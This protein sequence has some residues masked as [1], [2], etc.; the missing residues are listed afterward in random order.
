MIDPSGNAK[1]W[2]AYGQH[3]LARSYMPPVP[4]QLRWGFWDG[5]G[6][7]DEVLGP[8]TGR[9]VLDIGS[10]AGHYSVHLAT[11]HGALVD[12]VDLSP[13]QHQRAISHFGGVAGVR[14]LNLDVVEHL[15]QA[16]PYDAAYAI[17]TLSSI[18]PH[19]V[20]PALRDG[21]SPN[22]PLVFSTLHTNLHGHGPSSR[23]APREEKVRL[24][25]MEPLP[26]Q[27]W[28]LTGQVWED[29]LADYGFIVEA[30]D[31]LRA[32]ETDNPVVVQLIRA[33]RGSRS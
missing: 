16:P 14:F 9:R 21:L 13:T 20:L 10:G 23:V 3:Q 33:Y 7:G 32:P 4:G 27:T 25:G 26:V 22:A 6:P 24:V 31:L 29:L 17:G 12:A 28:V 2:T 19:S 11:A 1:T 8:I 5:V 15:R 18:D 30:I